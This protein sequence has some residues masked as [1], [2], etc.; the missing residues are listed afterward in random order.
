MLKYAV[1]FCYCV[2]STLEKTMIGCGVL[3][4]TNAPHWTSSFLTTALFSVQPLWEPFSASMSLN[5]GIESHIKHQ[6]ERLLSRVGVAYLL[7]PVCM[8]WI[9]CTITK[10]KTSVVCRNATNRNVE[11]KSKSITHLCAVR[12]FLGASGCF[13]CY[14]SLATRAQYQKN[15]TCLGHGWRCNLWFCVYTLRRVED[16]Y[17]QIIF[18]KSFI[19]RT[20]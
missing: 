17:H 14:L 9:T 13:V 16:R 5:V 19:K 7:E 1:V 3:L 18:W 8:L 20:A 2:F 4:P 15:L 6:C 10:S 11:G 12:L